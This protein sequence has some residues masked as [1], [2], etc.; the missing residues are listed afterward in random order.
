[1][2]Y[3]VNYWGEIGISP[4]LTE[5]DAA[6]L[7]AV[8]NN[9]PADAPSVFASIEAA[10]PKP[11]LP[12]CTGL[13]T[14]SED[15]SKLMPEEDDSRH[16]LD[17]WLQ[18]AR[19]FFLAPNGYVLEGSIDFEGED[20]DDRG[21]IFVKDN[22]LELVY[23]VILKPGPSWDRNHYATETLKQTIQDLL[24]SSDES[25]FSSDFIVVAAP[26]L[27]ELRHLLPLS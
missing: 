12:W 11:E 25:G 1:M 7:T 22:V 24:D 20:Q 19:D 2:G 21:T 5:A 27:R 16:G 6:I 14:V 9:K 13:L 10:D 3:S 23:D 4:A 26:P 15:R 17:T 18:I 8:L